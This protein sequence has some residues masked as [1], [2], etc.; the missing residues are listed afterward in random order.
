MI[1]PTEVRVVFMGTAGFAVPSLHSLVG[2]GYRIEAVVTQ[3]PRPAG[4]RRQMTP[5]PVM[6]AAEVL[7]LRTLHP[8][9]L[10]APESVAEIAKMKPDLIVVAAYGQLLPTSILDL[11]PHGCV[12]VHGSLLPRW[13]GASP[14]QSAILAGDDIT[15]VA[16]MMMEPSMDTGPVLAQS[17]TLIDAEDT[18]LLLEA[19]LARAGA[20]LLVAVVPLHVAGASVAV[21]QLHEL[22]SYA[23]VLRK[24]A[25]LIDWRS[26]ATHIWRA[27]RAFTPWPG[28]YSYWRGR[29]LKVVSAEPERLDL[30]E[31]PGTVVGMDEGKGA[32]VATGEGVLRLREVALEGARAMTV[33]EFL[34]GHR[35]FIGSRLE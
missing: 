18:A 34:A 3:P 11:P 6:E 14:I 4:R 5:S 30:P 19:R 9:K 20:S 35:D 27:S 1:D 10:R 15:G 13:R 12:N 16:L 21:P 32:G 25:G 33:R 22:A 2:A 17:R 28:T 24:D 7:G 23:P 8:E 29:L 31:E 26:P